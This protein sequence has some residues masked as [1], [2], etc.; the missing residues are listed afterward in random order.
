METSDTPVFIVGVGRSGTS[1]VHSM[2]AA[3]SNLAFPPE[4]S[5]LRRL[6]VNGTIANLLKSGFD[7]NNLPLL[8]SDRWIK[9]TGLSSK[10]LLAHARKEG[11]ITGGSLYR[12]LLSLYAKQLDKPCYGDKDPRSVEYLEIIAQT[13][14]GV[15]IIHVIRDPRDVLA[16]KKKAAWSH[17]RGSLYHIF[18]NRVQMRIGRTLGPKL[19]AQ[20]YHELI[21]EALIADPEA[22]LHNLCLQLG[23]SY[24]HKMLEFNRSAKELVSESEI[25][26]KK[27]TLGPLLK[28]NH[29]K[30]KQSLSDWEIAL[31]EMVCTDAFEAG[32]YEKVE[33]LRRMNLIQQIGVYMAA[34][35]ICILDPIYRNY[36]QWTVWRARRYV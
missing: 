34:A 25:S 23:L 28:D 24:E 27:E 15:M 6:I 5:F 3:H 35:G 36:R 4:T 14:P 1:L 32:G 16:S 19:L 29:G 11:V 17:K 22:V 7:N 21:Y 20:N 2:L 31:T 30:W 8:D 9:R 10:K 13:L 18:A 26:W 12:A 33:R